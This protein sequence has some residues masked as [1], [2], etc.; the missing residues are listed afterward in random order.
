MHLKTL[1]MMDKTE[2]P[3][4][5]HSTVG[6]GVSMDRSEALNVCCKCEARSMDDT[7]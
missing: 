4:G 2:V 3:Q 6:G 7:L 1:C 5:V